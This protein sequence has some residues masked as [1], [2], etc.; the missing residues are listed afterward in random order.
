MIS[1]PGGT[2]DFDLMSETLFAWQRNGFL[3]T[4]KP[5]EIYRTEQLRYFYV[6]LPHFCSVWLLFRQKRTHICL[7]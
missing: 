6:L 3:K 4:V 2:A 7:R 1:V 5:I